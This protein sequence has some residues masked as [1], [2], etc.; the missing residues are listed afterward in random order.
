MA[1]APDAPGTSEVLLHLL[2]AV[3]WTA[4]ADLRVTYVNARAEALLGDPIA[5]WLSEP[6]A[7]VRRLHP[8]DRDATVAAWRAVA[9]DGQPRRTEHRM[10]SADGATVWLRTH[11]SA[12]GG[13][14]DAEH[15]LVGVMMEIDLPRALPG[16]DRHTLEEQASRQARFLDS[17]V[18]NL[19]DMVFLKDARE[20][21]FVRFNRA[22]E[23]L[24]GY[25]REDL[26]GKNDYDFFPPAQADFFI[27]KDRAVLA[28]GEVVDIPE[29]P[30]ESRTR[31][32]R[33]LHTKKIPV[34]D[35][36]GHPLYLLGISRDITERKEA[37]DQR[38]MVYGRLEEL[39]ALKSAF[40]ANV[41]HELR[42]PLTLILGIVERLSNDAAIGAEGIADLRVVE[43]N[44]RVLL[45]HVNDLLDV[46]KLEAG[47]MTIEYAETDLARLVRLTASPFEV[48]AADRGIALTIEAPPALAAQVDAAKVQRVLTNLLANAVEFT[49][50]RGRVRCTLVHEDDRVSLAVA[51]SGPGVPPEL[52]ATVFER[53][54]QLEGGPTRRFG[55]TGLGLSIAKDLV[56]LHGGTIELGEALE[57]GALLTVTLPRTAP[58]GAKVRRGPRLEALSAAEAPPGLLGPAGAGA[59]R[60]ARETRGGAAQVE[61]PVGRPFV[62]VVEDNV[63]MNRFLRESLR[64]DF[65]TAAAFDG[66]EGL[67]LALRLRP[68]LILTDIMMPHVG[69]EQLVHAV[70]ARPELDGVPIII[71]TAKADDELRIRLLREGAQDYVTK[72]F[73]REELLARVKNL[74]SLKRA[75]DALSTE[76]ELQSQDIDL[77]ATEL[78]DQ[79]RELQAALVTTQRA[80]EL[81]EHATRVK[82]NFLRLVSHELRTPLT[83]LQLHLQSLKRRFDG[84]EHAKERERL[85]KMSRAAERLLEMVG[86]L[87]SSASIESGKLDLRIETLDLGEIV[88]EV[89]DELRIQ[90]DQKGLQLECSGSSGLPP[91]ESDAQILRLIL[92]NLVGNA[93]KFTVRGSV[94]VAL[95]HDRDEHH[96]AVSDTGPGIPAGKHRTI[97]EPFEQL[98]PIRHKH[99]VGIGLGLAITEKMVDRLGGRIELTSELGRGSTFTVHLPSRGPATGDDRSGPGSGAS[100]SH[101]P[102]GSRRSR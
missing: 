58:P 21:R 97:F 46:A 32:L 78:I 44:A 38:Q 39:D 65:R 54:V 52:R 12:A 74:A 94:S 31:G 5:Q 28:A 57:G 41:S 27:E 69:G 64:P 42:T 16:A 10:L 91:L 37:E 30:L 55:G 83:V 87:L 43:R 45:H 77:L 2:D 36:A 20:L 75:R 89:V 23:E 22:G 86:S 80:R 53:F 73:Q 47:R 50:P 17:I 63:E 72:P 101:A 15:T 1:T 33:F 60:A 93:L 85:R 40:F 25:R 14:V 102:D 70:R 79:K 6:D 8:D 48:P 4:G 9:R 90:A 3:V 18:E 49:P 84:P 29:E 59:E 76:V 100:P 82:T 26:I 51:D 95:S 35:E 71:L 92:A 11:V 13:E 98:E 68:D 7:L 96:I 19:P 99:I 67:E 61:G 88:R 62:L 66:R 56:E 24:L 81:A 34:Y